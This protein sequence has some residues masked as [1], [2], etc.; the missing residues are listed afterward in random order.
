MGRKVDTGRA[1]DIGKIPARARPNRAFRQPL[2]TWPRY[3]RNTN[4]CV[5]PAKFAKFSKRN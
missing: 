4:L 3:V 1:V 2:S 5:S